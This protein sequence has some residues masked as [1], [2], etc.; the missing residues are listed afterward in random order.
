MIC[1]VTQTFAGVNGPVIQGSPNGND[2]APY[3]SMMDNDVSQLRCWQYGKLIF[4]ENG[5]SAKIKESALV[6]EF[7]ERGSSK[8]Y[9]MNFGNSTCLYRKVR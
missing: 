2:D 5:W 4:E 7:V 8:L 3:K 1:A 6:Y 9:L